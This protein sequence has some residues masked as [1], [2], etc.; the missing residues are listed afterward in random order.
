MA[1]TAAIGAPLGSSTIRNYSLPNRLAL[2][3]NPA[4]GRRDRC[5]GFR[6]QA[7]YRS[8]EFLTGRDLLET[9]LHRSLK[10]HFAA[11]AKSVEV[12]LGAFR[13]D[14]IDGQGCLVEI[15]HAGLG[16]IR[17]KVR[18]LLELKHRVRVVKPLIALKVI[19]TLEYPNGPVLRRRKSP[20]KLT[21]ID[22]FKELIHFTDVFPH[23]SLSLEIVAVESV[24]QRIDLSLEERRHARA[25]RY[26]CL[27]QHLL[28]VH[29]G[30]ILRT[31]DDLWGVLNQPKLSKM[32]DSLELAE[33]VG[34]P[35][36]FAQQI[37]YCL[38]RMGAASRCG[39]RGN[40]I[41][42]ERV[43]H[44]RTKRS[45]TSKNKSMP[46]CKSTKRTGAA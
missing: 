30:V 35:R 8:G 33:A 43:Q 44:K 36:W 12:K 45:S 15:Q 38:D 22:V 3:P 4:I 17:F 37:A 31:A 25:K 18:K 16:S 27:D 34:V 32:F 21:T 42:Y 11:D 5:S 40:T 46:V 14:A 29:D 2:L 26:R 39:K 13:I 24:E 41:L 20:K 7:S 6:L 1:I 23:P 10:N 19:E 28:K 9:Q